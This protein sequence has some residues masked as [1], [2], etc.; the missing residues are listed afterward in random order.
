MRAEERWPSYAPAAAERGV[1]SSLSVPLPV[2]GSVIGA[3]NIYSTKPHAF[4]DADTIALAEEIARLAAVAIGNAT[5]YAN[6][7]SQA[8]QMAQAMASRAIIEQAKGVII[9]TRHCS[10]DQAFAFLTQASQRSNRK[11]RDLAREVV[12][13]A[14]RGGR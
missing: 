6:A 1:G 2:Q 14:S 10:A 11:L 7:T 13:G 4:D 12:E 9:A 3:L 8:E 5:S